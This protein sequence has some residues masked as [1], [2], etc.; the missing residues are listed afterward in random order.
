MRRLQTTAIFCSVAALAAASLACSVTV[1]WGNDPVARST[2][3]SLPFS[4]AAQPVMPGIVLSSDLANQQEALVSL[5]ETASQGVV[6]L[7]ID[8]PIGLRHGAGFVIDK[9]GHIVTNQ[10]VVD[11]ARGI[12]VVFHNGERAPAVV[13]G[14]DVDSD[15]AVIKVDVPPEQLVPLVF[16]DSEQVKVGQLVVAIGNPFGL[17]GSM[18]TGVVSNLA[19]TLPGL[20]STLLNEEN[21]FAVGDLIQTDAAINPGNSGGPLL[22]MYGE[23][24]GVNRA[25][26]TLYYN[27]DNQALSSGVGFAISSNVV[28][29]IVPSLIEKGLYEYP[30]IGMTSLTDLTLAIAEQAGL[31]HTRGAYVRQVLSGGPAE[32]AG[33]A[34]GDL[35]TQINGKDLNS[36]TE[37]AAYL[38]SHS[39]PGDVVN[40]IV[41]R[42]DQELEIELT[43]GSRPASTP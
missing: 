43:L 24:I 36:S 31:P 23:V 10:H 38:L 39:S 7:D 19:R 35:I 32:Q 13:L 37:L 6:S 20:N 9:A 15:L 18:S 3:A 2:D 42:V 33:L 26:R 34:E 40:L 28:Q 29:R 5:Y 27:Q 41:L 16:G 22:N 11:R 12:E 14:I 30:F 21:I 25:I 8:S 4:D 1:D 17:E